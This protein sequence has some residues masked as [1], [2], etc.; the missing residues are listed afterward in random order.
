MARW[1][2]DGG[3]PSTPRSSCWWTTRCAAANGSRTSTAW[4]SPRTWKWCSPRS[5][6]RSGGGRGSER[7]QDLHRQGGPPKLGGVFASI[8]EAEGG[9]PEWEADDRPGIL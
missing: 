4:A 9:L 6:R 2:W 7:E 8:S 5:A 3:N 1:W